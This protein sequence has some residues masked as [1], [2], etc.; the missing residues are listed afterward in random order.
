[1]GQFTSFRSSTL[2]RTNPFG[3]VGMSCKISSLLMITIVFLRTPTLLSSTLICVTARQ[4]RNLSA[5]ALHVQF[6]RLSAHRCL[7]LGIVTDV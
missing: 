1:M 4:S 6:A 3:R 5:S 7:S 2:P